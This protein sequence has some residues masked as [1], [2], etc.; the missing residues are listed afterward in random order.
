MADL[1]DHWQ[2]LRA[3]FAR[4]GRDAA[5]D[6]GRSHL[7]Q[8]SEALRAMLDDKTIPES[9]R[10]ELRDDFA[11]VEAMLGKLEQGELHIAVFGRVSVG[12]SALGNALLGREIFQTGV[13]HGTTRRRDAQRW[14]E[15]GGQG[16]HLIDTPGINELSG[17]ERERLAFDVAG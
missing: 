13:L 15:V 1:S 11:Q 17:E 3:R 7:A 4:S 6:D 9:V 12:K 10:A 16:L 14:E 2:R 5:P 8:A